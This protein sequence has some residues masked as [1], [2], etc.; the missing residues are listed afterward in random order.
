MATHSSLLAW[1]IPIGQRSLMGC[2]PWG[3]KESDTT[4]RLS[5][6][7]SLFPGYDQDQKTTTTTTQRITL[8]CLESSPGPPF[9]KHALGVREP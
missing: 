9:R 8:H 3:C 7:Q 2:S 1:R 6:A 4:E 5:T